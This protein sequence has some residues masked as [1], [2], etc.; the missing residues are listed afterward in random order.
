MKNYLLGCVLG[1]VAG[2]TIGSTVTH[3]MADRVIERMATQDQAINEISKKITEKAKEW[4]QRAESCEQK[5]ANDAGAQQILQQ[6][7]QIKTAAA[8]RVQ[9]QQCPAV[10]DA[11]SP[12]L[13]A[14]CL[15]ANQPMPT[16]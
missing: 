14:L 5:A 1:L 7:E 2:L 9:Q 13:R 8:A 16:Q 12:T 6:M 10:L 4:K 11:L 15:A 3:Y